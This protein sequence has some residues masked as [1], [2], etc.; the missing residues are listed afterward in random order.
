MWPWA[1]PSLMWLE[2]CGLVGRRGTIEVRSQT[3]QPQHWLPPAVRWPTNFAFTTVSC[4]LLFC[5]I[6]SLPIPMQMI[7]H[8]ILSFEQLG[9]AR[10]THASES[11][12][13][14]VSFRRVW[15]EEVTA[16]HQ[17]LTTVTEFSS[18]P[19]LSY[20]IHQNRYSVWSSSNVVWL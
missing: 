10:T 6:V 19:W 1:W 4:L 20:Y 15:L 3:R 17:Q 7:R 11:V 12:A 16:C 2:E 13:V 8:S 18:L 9:I 5:K 14:F